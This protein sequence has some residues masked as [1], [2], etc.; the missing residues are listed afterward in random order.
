MTLVFL[1]WQDE[2]AARADRRRGVRRAAGRARRRGCAAADVQPVPPRNPR[3]FALDL[4]DEGGRAAA[5]QAG[6][7]GR[8]RGRRLVP[9]R[10]AP[11]LAAHH[12]RAGEARR[13]P[14][15]AAAGRPRR[16]RPS[17]SRRAC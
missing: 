15:A 2:S 7:V 8:P 14:R 5:L 4:E 9:A 12:A 6:D 1:G 13:A 3:L 16:R 17:R 10:E 11:L